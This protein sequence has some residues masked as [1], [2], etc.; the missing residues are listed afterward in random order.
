[1]ER[2]TRNRIIVVSV[3]ALLIAGVGIESAIDK[4]KSN[5]DPTP[6]P[7]ATAVRKYVIKSDTF[8]AVDEQAFDEIMRASVRKDNDQTLRLLSSGRVVVLKQGT[9][10]DL[11]KVKLAS[12][13]KIQVL[14]G[15][16]TDQYLFVNSA[17]IEQAK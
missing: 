6:T 9:E 10:V 13:T 8:G 2:I 12:G 1:M 7:T 11:I 15:T 14:S 17:L 5:S 3:V 16:Y 4:E